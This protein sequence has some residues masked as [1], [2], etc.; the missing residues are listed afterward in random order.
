MVTL[1]YTLL[2]FALPDLVLLESI[3]LDSKGFGEDNQIDTNKSRAG[4]DNNRRVEIKVT[5]E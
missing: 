3:G 2:L 1:I 5:N 4:R